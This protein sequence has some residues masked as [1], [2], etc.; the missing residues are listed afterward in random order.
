MGRGEGVFLLCAVVLSCGGAPA[1]DRAPL[2]GPDPWATT[3][4]LPRVTDRA[5]DPRVVEIDLEARVGEWE[6]S[7][8]RRVRAMTY[9]GTVPGPTI[10]ARAG[11]T[12]VV[13]FTNRLEEP[14]TVH[15]HGL[16]VPANMDGGPHSQPP[17]APG[18][19]FEYRFTVPDAGTFWYHP[20]VHEGV[21]MER[22]LYG[23]IVV[24]GEREPRADAEG[25]LLLDDVLLGSDGQLAPP[26]DLLEQHN[27]REGGVSVVNGR[28]DATLALRAGQRQRWRI[29]NAGSARFHRLSLP[30][31]RFTVVG[32][33]GGL[34]PVPRAVDELLL[35]PG[36]RVDVLVDG[37]GAPGSAT[38]LRTLPYARGHGAGLTQPVE[39]LRVQYAPEPAVPLLSAPGPGPAIERLSAQGVTPREVTFNERVDRERERVVFLIN[40]RSFP[41]V[42]DL[43]T[44]VGTTEVWD[45]VNESEMEHPFHLHGFFF[46]VLSRNNTP[47]ADVTW[48]DTLQLRGHERVRIAFRPDARPGHWMYHCHILEHVDN[49][50]MAAVQVT[51]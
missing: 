17:I 11:D 7:P 45:L 30:G 18:G 5:P 27:G 35:V 34:V 50:M 14:T 13:H 2:T 51:P 15:W 26:G 37:V 23:A 28:A 46:Q 25:V 4:A 19:T 6:L 3:L 8:G 33:D 44:R 42:P 48:E 38:T 9:N 40:N 49:G 20:H 29:V 22:G 12:V 24:R 21:Q 36:D 41:D 32:T 10:E 31:H 47:E 16:R 1:P 39:L 43:V